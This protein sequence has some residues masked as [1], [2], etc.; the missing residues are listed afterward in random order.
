[1]SGVCLLI[2]P[3]PVH[4]FSIT[5]VWER[6]TILWAIL[7]TKPEVVQF[8]RLMKNCMKVEEGD[9]ATFYQKIRKSQ[10][11]IQNNLHTPYNLTFH[12]QITT[13][14][15]GFNNVVLLAWCCVHIIPLLP[16]SERTIC[17]PKACNIARLHS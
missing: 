11:T 13:F 12:N 16:L 5:F 7:M 10:K 17:S 15:Q 4:C 3:V 9:F 1:M 8:P 2:A 6:W 14:W